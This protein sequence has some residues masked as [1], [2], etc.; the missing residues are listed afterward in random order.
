MRADFYFRRTKNF[1]LIELL[2]V[3]AIIALL[4]AML[5]PA[6]NK[7]KALA[8]TISCVNSGKQLGTC[9]AMYL[10]DNKNMIQ[11]CAKIG[12]TDF[13]FYYQLKTGGYTKGV[14]GYCPETPLPIKSRDNGDYGMRQ[15]SQMFY[16]Q[17]GI[18]FGSTIRM[19]KTWT[20][21]VP[22]S[23]IFLGDAVGKTT[24]LSKE[25]WSGR[26]LES[27]GQAQSRLSIAHTRHNE[28][29][30]IIY[31]DFH[32]KTIGPD[33]LFDERTKVQNWGYRTKYGKL[34]R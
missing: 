12:A 8:K 1:T 4:A 10:Q 32:V 28:R 23:M 30:N 14:V 3:I 25:W 7:A 18:Y 2:V 13:A 21:K 15:D 31:G 24:D 27:R 26:Y 20:W 9:I 16:Y 19:G 29:I 34:V 33:E 17:E 5:L 11:A 6:L 22:S